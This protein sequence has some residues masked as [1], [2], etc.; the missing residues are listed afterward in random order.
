[1]AK[2]KRDHIVAI[3][4]TTKKD[5]THKNSLIELVMFYSHSRICIY[6]FCLYFKQ[7]RGYAESYKYIYLFQISNMRNSFL[8]QIR[9]ELSE[10]SK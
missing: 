10:D 4:K 6:F 9:D 3:S 5:K 1:M 8:K 2:S 7:I